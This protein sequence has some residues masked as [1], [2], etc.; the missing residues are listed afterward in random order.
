MGAERP[1]T[2]RPEE[3]LWHRC[4]KLAEKHGLTPLEVLKQFIWAGEE[5]LEVEEMG[6]VVT[7]RVGSKVIEIKVFDNK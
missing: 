7:G 2:V 5:V 1:P 6:G 4:E 3:E